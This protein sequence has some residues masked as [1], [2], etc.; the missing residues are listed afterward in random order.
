MSMPYRAF[1]LLLLTLA[2]SAAAA[3][4]GG[5]S[6][7]TTEGGSPAVPAAE[8]PSS[9][10]NTPQQP[11][12]LMIPTMAAGTWPYVSTETLAP[13]FEQV[14]PKGSQIQRAPTSTGDISGLYLLR[15]GQGDLYMVSDLPAHWVWEGLP[16][17]NIDKAYQG[18]RKLLHI[19]PYAGL[20]LLIS[21]DIV[22]ANDLK[23]IDDLFEK[24]VKFSMAAWPSGSSGMIFV[25][26]ILKSYGFENIEDFEAKGNTVLQGGP[27]D[28]VKYVRDR[29]ADAYFGMIVGHNFPMAEEMTSSVDMVLLPYSEEKLKEIMDEYGYRPFVVPTD[30][31]KGVEQDTTILGVGG[32]ITV[33]EETSDEVAYQMTK[34]MYDNWAEIQ[35]NDPFFSITPLRFDE[36]IIPWHPGA[37]KYLKE[38]G[39]IK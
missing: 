14:L 37:E 28:Q 7:E 10:N 26:L 3:C 11:I 39:A 20:G 4:S 18:F 35:K 32:Y 15:A 25:D 38:A 16:Y 24:N 6:V 9:S 33:T 2:I 23:D 30:A 34:V 17:P 27:Q 12:Q 22:E 13:Y 1:L 29:Q 19:E 8:N 21:R 5:A 36:T 31:Y